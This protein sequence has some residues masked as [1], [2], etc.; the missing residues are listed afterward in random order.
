MFD[1]LARF[2][3]AALLFLPVGAHAGVITEIQYQSV[4]ARYILSGS[5]RDRNTGVGDATGLSTSIVPDPPNFLGTASIDG[6]SSTVGLTFDLDQTNNSFSFDAAIATVGNDEDNF[7]ARAVVA[8]RMFIDFTIVSDSDDL[9]ELVFSVDGSMPGLEE[10]AANAQSSGGA[11]LSAVSSTTG[12]GTFLGNFSLSSNNSAV[13]GTESF[14]VRPGDSYRILTVIDIENRPFVN[15][16]P[17][18][19]L[20][21]DAVGNFQFTSRLAVR[22]VPEPW[23]LMTLG[24]G[25][26]TIGWRRKS[27]LMQ[28]ILPA[29]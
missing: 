7:I 20:H 14:L 9:V 16:P 5:V 6:A 28:Q 15:I 21:L 22:D 23:M 19:N 3:V 11:S 10:V 1:Q 29:I 26:L 17:F 2:T 8:I 13:S 18:N 12:V 4:T 24:F 25:L 27:A